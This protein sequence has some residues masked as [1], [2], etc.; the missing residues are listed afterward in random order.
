M[1]FLYC[2]KKD[3]SMRWLLRRD[4]GSVSGPRSNLAC[5]HVTKSG[6]SGSLQLEGRVPL[7]PEA[8][9]GTAEQETPRVNVARLCRC[10]TKARPTPG[11]GGEG[12]HHHLP[13]QNALEEQIWMIIQQPMSLVEAAGTGD[14]GRQK[15]DWHQ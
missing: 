13:Y 11:R 15:E 12:E 10:Q 9:E 3:A 2:W 5:P 6:S 1:R 4:V 7:V 14:A 8:Q